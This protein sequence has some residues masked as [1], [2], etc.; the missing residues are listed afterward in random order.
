MT[1]EQPEREAASTSRAR[2]I[3]VV[4]DELPVLGVARRILQRAG[5]DV[6]EAS[7]A[8]DALRVADG[9]AGRLDLLLTD[10]SMPTVDGI[11]LAGLL[12]ERRPG[13]PVLY[14][15]GYTAHPLFSQ[16][17]GER[18]LRLVQKPFVT[19]IFLAAVASAIS[20]D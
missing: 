9:F 17:A 8:A 16:A 13:L 19:D 2:T 10:V 12:R 11:T 5:Y 1:M 6:L 3:L 14:M 18:R 4:D 20:S 15:S 7:T